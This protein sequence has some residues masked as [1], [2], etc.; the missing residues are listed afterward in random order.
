[1]GPAPRLTEPIDLASRY[2]W[3]PGGPGRRRPACSTGSG[4]S[5]P[6]RLSVPAP[7][8]RLTVFAW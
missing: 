3:P 1:M 2:R 4:R 6:T 5:P 8:G 7:R